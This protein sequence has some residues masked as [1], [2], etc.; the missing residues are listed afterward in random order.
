M[1]FYPTNLPCLEISKKELIWKQKLP[2]K[3][4]RKYAF[5]RSYIRLALSEFF[6]ISPLDVP[7]I[8][9]PGKQ[10]LLKNDRGFIS[11]S[12]SEEILVIAWAPLNIG[13]DIEN[14]NRLFAAEKISKRI[15]HISEQKE[16][17]K[18]DKYLFRK[19]ALK[20]WIIKEAAYKWQLK[21]NKTDF[22]YW[23]WIKNSNFAINKN[24]KLKVNT[25]LMVKEDYFL[26]IA[27]NS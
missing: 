18:F 14:K 17:S 12:H 9:N 7:L 4:F 1:W 23:E 24:N 15:F 20:Y 8:S 16:L 26:G 6:K 19:E 25:Y 27:Y 10:P 11:L 22:F 3:A 2:E 21:K 13:V 5:S